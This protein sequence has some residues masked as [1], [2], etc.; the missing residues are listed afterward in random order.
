VLS[1]ILSDSLTLQSFL[2]CSLAS[3]G[4]G[5]LG[6]LAYLFRNTVNKSFVITL[7]I[8]PVIVQVVIMMVNGSVGAGLAVMGAFSLVRFR[9]VPG[10]A[11]EISNIFLAMAM[12]LTCG[13]GYLGVAALLLVIVSGATILLSVI[14]FAEQ[15]VE[16]KELKITI[17]ESL[18][19]TGIFD[20]LF[21]K[22]TNKSELIRVRTTNMGSLYELQ[23]HIVLKD[24]TQVKPLIDDI[25][26]RNGNLNIICGRVPIS[27]ES[28]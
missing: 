7:S 20:D 28:I 8:L 4:F 25:R 5:I 24:P 9:S 26:C 15:T 3:L 23:Y 21:E 16:E 22:Y 13:M 11:R 19:Y 2:L 14:P 10:T 27:K 1:S 17:P 18:D 6:A 12:G